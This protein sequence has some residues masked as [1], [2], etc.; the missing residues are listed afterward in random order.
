MEE[1]WARRMS[2]KEPVVAIMEEQQL[3]QD[4]YEELWQL[5]ASIDAASQEECKVVQKLLAAISL[6]QCPSLCQPQHRCLGPLTSLY[7]TTRDRT[8]SLLFGC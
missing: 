7:P 1:F 6:S 5:W 2:L 3:F 8:R 4:N